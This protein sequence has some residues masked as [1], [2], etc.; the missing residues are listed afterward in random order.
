MNVKKL[1]K[2][3]KFLVKAKK[4]TYAGGGKEKKLSD[5]SREL[6]FKQG[7]FE[8]R[9][10]Y[11]GSISFIGQ[12]VVFYDK[13]IIWGTNYYGRVVSETI[14]SD[15]IYRFLKKALKKIT[16][17]K[18]FRG[19]DNFQLENFKYTNKVKGKIDN[20][21]GNEIIFYKKEIVYKLNYHGGLVKIK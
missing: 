21:K 6:R 15:Q 17:N 1:A 3:N 12:E 16:E 13:K 8:Y 14:F 2:L 11:F 7:K 20:F 18:P 10:R 5:Q 9:D 19:P 4:N